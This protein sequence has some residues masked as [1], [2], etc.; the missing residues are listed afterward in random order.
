MKMDTLVAQAITGDLISTGGALA[1]VVVGGFLTVVVEGS[2]Q[3]RKDKALL[4]ASTRLLSTELAETAS[5]L[6]DLAETGSIDRTKFGAVAPS[7]ES[8][9]E[10]LADKLGDETWDGVAQVITSAR[11]LR[12]RIFAG[13]PDEAVVQ[14]ASEDVRHRATGLHERI[15]AVAAGLATEKSA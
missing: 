12:L 5:S 8:Y 2:R 9:R 6:H 11:Q 13:M 7:W 15:V 14:A 10:F 1:G 4:R 3:K